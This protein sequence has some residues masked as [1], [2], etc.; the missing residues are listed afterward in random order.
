MRYLNYDSRATGP[1]APE[2][3]QERR[4]GARMGWA[5]AHAVADAHAAEV[6]RIESDAFALVA[7]RLQGG[8]K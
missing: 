2:R 3:P 1:R 5:N 4:N 7:R 8:G 6:T